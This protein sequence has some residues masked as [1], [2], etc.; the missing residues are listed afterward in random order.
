M[1]ATSDA[2]ELRPSHPAPREL[3]DALDNVAGLRLEGEATGVQVTGCTLDSRKVRPGDLYAAV[4]GA[5]AH[6][7][8]FATQAV[9]AGA[10]AVLTDDAG[11]AQ[12]RGVPVLVADQVRAVLG[13]VAAWAY[14]NPADQLSLLGVTGTNGKTTTAFMMEA[15]LR[16]AGRPAALLGTIM[17]RIG[18]VELASARTTPEAPELQGMFALMRER[19]VQSVAMELSSHALAVGRADGCRFDAAV[20]TNFARDHLEVHATMEDYFQAKASLF[21]PQLASHGVINCDD[22]AGRRLLASVEIPTTTFGRSESADWRPE[23]VEA[24]ANGSDFVLVGPGV[25][26]KASVALPGDFNVLNAVGAVAALAATGVR[27]E[28]AVQGIASMEGIPGHMERVDAG[29]PFAAFV[30][31]AH[32]PEA[33]EKLLCAVRGITTGRVII[34]LGCGGDRDPGKR[35]LMGRAGVAGADLA[36]FTSDNPRSEDPLAILAQMGPGAVV[37]PDRRTAIAYAV[38]QARPGDT[39][40]VAGKGH[41][42]GQE[43]AGVVTPFDDRL[44]LRQ[45]ITGVPA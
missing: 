33:V 26:V 29:Q 5:K 3:S 30:D 17:S 19:E 18:E 4:P 41:E 15:G 39:V 22:E 40:V 12:V 37:E 1:P 44:V 36:V 24:R 43:V 23:Q 8:A 42:T 21:R 34:V 6:G 31:F 25:R 2:A 28:D 27:V 16:A 10:V 35:P 32:T 20:F 9:A 11:A 13:R 45:E 7:A 38:A 14:G